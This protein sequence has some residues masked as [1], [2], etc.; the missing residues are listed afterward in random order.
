MIPSSVA[1]P[2]VFGERPLALRSERRQ[3]VGR[4][5]HSEPRSEE[6]PGYSAESLVRLHHHRALTM[7]IQPMG[8]LLTAIL[9][10]VIIRR[11]DI[12]PTHHR[13]IKIQVIPVLPVTPFPR[14]TDTKVRPDTPP[15]Q[16][17]WPMVHQPAQNSPATSVVPA[18]NRRPIWNTHPTPVPLAMRTRET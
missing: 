7:A 9:V 3:V 6:Q 17:L 8:T 4:G 10:T 16:A 14:P 2:V 18:M 11:K 5:P 1:L 13:G 12:R 15:I